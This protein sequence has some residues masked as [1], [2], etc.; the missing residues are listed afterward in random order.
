[1]TRPRLALAAVSIRERNIV[2]TPVI[3]HTAIVGSQ[4][5]V[6]LAVV[7]QGEP[8]RQAGPGVLTLTRDVKAGNRIIKLPPTK[9]SLR[10]R[11]VPV[12]AFKS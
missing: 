8:T 4:I 9:L 6:G 3:I 2:I 10:S 5:D 11:S 1:M 12:G 7:W